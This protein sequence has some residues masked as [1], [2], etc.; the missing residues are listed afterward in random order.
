[1]NG[2]RLGSFD[3]VYSY[4]CG[5]KVVWGVDLVV[6]NE[7]FIYLDVGGKGGYVCVEFRVY[8]NFVSFV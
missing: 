5:G 7:L 2:N 6:I 1:M 8:E 4:Y 3:L